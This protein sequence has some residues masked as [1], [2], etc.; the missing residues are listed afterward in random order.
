MVGLVVYKNIG[1]RG[2]HFGPHCG[3]DKNGPLLQQCFYGQA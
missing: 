3:G 1:V 2:G